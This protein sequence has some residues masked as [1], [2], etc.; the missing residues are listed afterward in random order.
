MWN[1]VV[2]MQPESGSRCSKWRLLK[3]KRLRHLP[4]Q[5]GFGD[6]LVEVPK[7]RQRATQKQVITLGW[8]LL[9]CVGSRDWEL[10]LF[11]VTS[12]GPVFERSI[13]PGTNCWHHINGPSSL[14]W[15]SEG[16]KF[17]LSMFRM[18][19]RATS[20]VAFVV[21]TPVCFLCASISFGPIRQAFEFSRRSDDQGRQ[22]D[23][24]ELSSFQ[25]R[26]FL[27]LQNAR[28]LV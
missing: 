15:T 27:L 1:Q 12:G 24:L 6:A 11:L 23:E 4:R 14:G 13:E 5:R 10:F 22:L 25:M 20:R 26:E 19:R 3:G 28:C 2:K 7:P 8:S 17:W 9:H 21:F 16:G 18:G